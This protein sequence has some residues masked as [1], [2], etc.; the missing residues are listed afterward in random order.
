MRRIGA[1][2][3]VLALGA[4]LSGCWLQVGNGPGRDYFNPDETTI[5]AADVGSLT[6][7]WDADL[8]GSSTAPVVNGNAIYVSPGQHLVRLNA[9]TGAVDWDKGPFTVPDGN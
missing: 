4:S 3:G 6:P 5:T 7:L 2:A 1:A 9:T 8:G